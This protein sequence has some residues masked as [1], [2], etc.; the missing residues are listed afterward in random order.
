M[1]AL[2]AALGVDASTMSRNIAVLA[3]EKYVARARATEDSRVVTVALTLR[4]RK[5]L[6]TLRCDEQDIMAR[7]FR[8]LP[9][10]SR[11]AIV[12]ALEVVQAALA[13]GAPAPAD[14]PC[15]AEPAAKR[16]SR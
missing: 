1:G 2:S 4:G 13:V 14:A 7:V 9:T 5:A 11:G 8:R 15:C 12:E 10:A 3:R 6:E 16:D